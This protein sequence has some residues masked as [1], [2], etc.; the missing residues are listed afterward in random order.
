MENKRLYFLDHLR[1]L[2]IFLVVIYHSI[3]IFTSALTNSWLVVD[4]VKNENLGLLGMYLDAF[5][6]FVLF[7][8]S[9]YFMPKA[10]DKSNKEFVIGKFKRLILPWVFG[11][12]VVIPIYKYIYLYSRGLPQEEFISYFHFFS[13]QGSDLTMFSNNPTQHW[14]W[15]LPVLFV[16]QIL[17]LILNRLNLTK[18]NIN[19]YQAVLSLVVLS[20]TFSVLISYFDLKG[21]Y[22]SYFIDF[23]IER[24]AV[25]FLFFLLGSKIYSMNVFHGKLNKKIYIWSNVAMSLSMT[26]YTVI[27]LNFFFNLIDANRE[28]YFLSSVGDRLFYYLS[29][30][31][32]ALSFIHILVYP[33]YNSLNKTN[34]FSKYLNANSYYVYI[35]HMVV[36]GIVAIPVLKFEIPLM[37]KFAII[38]ILAYLLSN[39]LVSMYEKIKSV[40]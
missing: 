20:T 6:M 25:Y 34:S 21:W 23:Q 5:V 33:F 4:E 24:I 30:Y 35:I 3:F 12:L 40:F 18:V 10:A 31:I 28:F 29:L 9:G 38:S 19:I 26:I 8:I 13:R 14:L 1:T 15:F 11:V 22:H 16:F 39:L 2:M 17:Y 27:S 7:F 32:L 37:L 36:I